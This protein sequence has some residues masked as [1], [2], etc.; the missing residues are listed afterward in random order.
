MDKNEMHYRILLLA[1]LIAGMALSTTGDILSDVAA[2]EIAYS[3]IFTNDPIY[4]CKVYM[5]DAEAADVVSTMAKTL[6]SVIKATDVTL[7]RSEYS[8]S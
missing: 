3:V 1:Q 6:W 2:R 7:L 5:S 4:Y 8:L